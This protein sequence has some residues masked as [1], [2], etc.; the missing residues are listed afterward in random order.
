MLISRFAKADRIKSSPYVTYEGERLDP[1]II[2]LSSIQTK[3]YT[4]S[5]PCPSCGTVG[6]E[7]LQCSRCG[8]LYCSKHECRWC[9]CPIMERDVVAMTIITRLDEQ[10]IYNTTR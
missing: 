10:A 9:S 5:H 7:V 4:E 8:K 3:V 1:E 2:A 6:R